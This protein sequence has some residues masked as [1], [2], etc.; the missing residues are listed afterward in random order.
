MT[1]WKRLRLGIGVAIALVGREPLTIAA[2]PQMKA[3]TS[4]ERASPPCAGPRF[5]EFDFWLGEWQVTSGGQPVATSSIE[6]ILGGCVIL[7]TYVD[8]SGYSGKSFNFYDTHLD[9]WRQT[10]V[11][12]AGNVSEFSGIVRDG[13]MN[14]QGETH[15]EGKRILR[16]MTVSK[17]RP[18]CVR[19]YSEQ[20]ADGGRTWTVAYDF[21]YLALR[22]SRAQNEAPMAIA[23]KTSEIHAKGCT[24]AAKSPAL[25]SALHA[26]SPQAA[27]TP[28]GR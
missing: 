23:T 1:V 2:G 26:V 22:R 27:T 11:D 13:S 24:P 20:S 17:E 15:R 6:T 28:N 8:P 16:K 14:Y 12:I 7:E 5:R 9:R 21:I 10:W 19:Q 3:G 18:D 25:A 4:S